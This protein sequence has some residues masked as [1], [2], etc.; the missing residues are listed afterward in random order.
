MRKI[1]NQELNR[2]SAE[3]FAEEER[4]VSS[5]LTNHDENE[6]T[7][8]PKTLTEYTFI[9]LATLRLAML[10]LSARKF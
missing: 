3:E 5:M 8:R 10:T 4:M 6:N 7:L 9:R 1:T 2:P